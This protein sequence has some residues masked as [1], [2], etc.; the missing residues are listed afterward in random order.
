MKEWVDYIGVWTGALIIN[1][2]NQVLLIKRSEKA[3]NEAWY[4]SQPWWSVEY[5]E[6]FIDATIREVKEELDVDIKILRMLSL[7][8]HIIKWEKQHWICPT[9]LAKISWW[10]LK[11]LEPHKHEEI[12]WFDLNNLPE[13]MT[14]YTKEATNEFKNILNK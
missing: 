5:W 11:N 10:E 12:K 1:D 6:T 14:K 9:Y 4:W 8:D 13:K 3:K 7:T 2:N